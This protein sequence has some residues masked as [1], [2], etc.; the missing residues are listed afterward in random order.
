MTVLNENTILAKAGETLRPKIRLQKGPS[1]VL[2]QDAAFTLING[3]GL[4]D[5]TKDEN[6]QDNLNSLLSPGGSS[7]LGADGSDTKFNQGGD[8]SS[9]GLAMLFTML[10]TDFSSDYLTMK[11]KPTSNPLEWEFY[12]QVGVDLIG[13]SN[14]NAD[15]EK[16]NMM[17]DQS[18]DKF[19]YLPG[20]IDAYQMI[21]GTFA[22]KTAS[23]FKDAIKSG[24]GNEKSYG[25]KLGGF[26]EGLLV[27]E[28]GSW[29]MRTRSGGVHHRSRVRLYLERKYLGGTDPRGGVGIRRRRS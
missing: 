13:D 3:V 14:T 27:Y 11:F 16:N 22:E 26:Y 24:V 23:S 29:R 17:I 25:G 8:M 5:M 19:K 6:L 1:L 18:A 2:L 7:V 21:K 20:P 15:G 9:P 28:N 4:P 10:K 12:I